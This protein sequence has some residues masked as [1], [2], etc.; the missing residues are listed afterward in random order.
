MPD[1][2]EE[3][4]AALG[5]APAF[6]DAH[7]GEAL[8]VSALRGGLRAEKQSEKALSQQGSGPRHE[9]RGVLPK[10]CHTICGTMNTEESYFFLLFTI[11]NMCCIQS[12]NKLFAVVHIF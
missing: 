2:R 12:E 1:V 10:H 7:G 9:R 4:P 11:T 8:R 3:V 5:H 6:A